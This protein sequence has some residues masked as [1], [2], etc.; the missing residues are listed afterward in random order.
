M[1]PFSDEDL[2][3]ASKNYLPKI[4]EYIK[5]HE[6]T[7]RLLG[8]L[9]GTIYIEL[10]GTCNGCSMSTMTTKMVVEKKLRELIHPEIK[11]E[12]IF[13]GQEDTLP[14]GIYRG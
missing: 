3:V 14:E 11:V 6:G 4:E 10:G 7:M 5:S 9:D 13:P 12:S 2:Y 8:V 1:I